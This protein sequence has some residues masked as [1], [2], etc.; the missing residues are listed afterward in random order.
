MLESSGTLGAI[1]QNATGSLASRNVENPRLVAELL[2]AHITGIPRLELCLSQNDILQ[3]QLQQKFETMVGRAANGEPVQYIMGETDFMG[4][5][6]EVDRRVLIPRP[7]TEILVEEVLDCRDLW[8]RPKPHIADIGTGSGAI[9]ISLTVLRPN[10]ECTAVDMSLDALELAQHNAQNHGVAE[11]ICWQQSDLL[12]GFS[13]CSLDAVVSNPPY[14]PTAD[15]EHLPTM[16]RLFEPPL[17]LDGGMN[18]LDAISRLV[19]TAPEALKSGGYIFMETGAEQ[20]QQVA[21]TMR[22][23]KWRNVEVIQD[24]TGRD[25]I[26]RGVKK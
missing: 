19:Q 18:G 20:A 14:I 6:F 11:L 3:N 21:A 2:A 12:D 26:V 23:S 13:P 5:R 24:L 16:V 1:I 25:R 22:N 17:A 10:I 8:R 7:E 4:L 9:A 15:C